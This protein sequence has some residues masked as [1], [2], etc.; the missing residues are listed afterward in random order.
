LRVSVTL[1]PGFTGRDAIGTGTDRRRH[2]GFLERRDVDGVAGKYRHQAEDQRQFAVLDAAEIE[3]YRERV[4]RF[5]LCDFGI[6][7]AMV[8]APLSR[9]RA[10]ENSTSSGVAPAA[11]P[12]NAL[13]DRG[14]R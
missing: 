8:G 3:P 2:R 5:G 14:G 11:R 7:L 12:K 6:I 1:A 13:W 9:N 4:G 10:H